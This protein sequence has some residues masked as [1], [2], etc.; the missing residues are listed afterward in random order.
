MRD[1][2]KDKDYFNHSIKLR[3]DLL[4]KGFKLLK[5]GKVTETQIPWYKKHLFD[6][7]FSNL[8]SGYS[9][10]NAKNKIIDDFYLC[11]NYL[12]E[13][14]DKNII[15]VPEKGDYLNQYYLDIYDQMLWM[16][17]LGY[18]LD[19]PNNE[20]NKLVSIID[21]DKVKDFL[22]EFII[23]AKLPDRPQITEESYLKFF[24][25]PQTFEK[26]R[27]AINQTDKDYTEKLVKGFITK[28]WYKKHKDA[29]WYDNH[30]SKHESYVG[31]WSFE[32]AV[33]VKIKGLDD[34]SFRDCIYYPKDLI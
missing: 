5:K 33:I 34:I 12:P 31:Y 10:G 22:F 7:Y 8:F 4:Q 19:I 14:W 29:G 23:R 16:L 2:I 28:D 20:F 11:L 27:E 24:G 18:L 15:R 30:K 13:S 3:N 1:R 9:V 26:L 25:V 32:T 6:M 17:S 21:R